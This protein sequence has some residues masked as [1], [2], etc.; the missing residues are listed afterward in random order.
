MKKIRYLLII[1]LCQY[2]KWVKLGNTFVN[3]IKHFFILIFVQVLVAEEFTRASPAM[4]M[5][6]VG[7]QEYIRA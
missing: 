5:N 3:Y 4:A 2:G 1:N 6:I 7:K